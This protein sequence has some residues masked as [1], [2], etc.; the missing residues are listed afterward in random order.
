MSVSYKQLFDKAYKLHNE[1][2]IKEAEK[3]YNILLEMSPEDFNVLNLY[4]LLCISKKD[5]KKAVNLLSK[6]V[7]LSKSPYVICNLAK[8]HLACNECEKALKL[9]K[10]AA[11]MNYQDG[12]LYYSMAITYKKLKKLD[13]AAQ[14]YEKAIEINP[15]NYNAGYNLIVVYRDLKMYKEAINY[16]NRC[17]LIK[18]ESEEIYSLLSYLY[19]CV[20]DLKSAI[21]ALEKAVKINPTQYLYY[22]NLGV[23]Y[24]K[25]FDPENSILNYK[26]VIELKPNSVAALVNLSCLYRKED[27][28]LSLQYILKAREYSPKAKNV[29][30]NLSQIYKDLYKNN[31][32]IEVLNE[33]LESNSNSHEAFSLLGMN[34]MDIGDYNKALDFYEK[35][36][37]LQPDNSSYLHGKAVAL[38][39]LGRIDEFKAL[40]NTVLKKDPNTCEVRITMGMAYLA[41]KNFNKG[42]ELYRARNLSTN[43][44]RI[45]GKKIWQ[46][47]ESIEKKDIVVYSNCGLGDTLMYARYLNILAD[48]ANSVILQTDEPLLSLLQP[49]FKNIKIINKSAKIGSNFDIAIPIM[50]IPYVLKMDFSNIPAS[51]GYIKHD[52]K[53]AEKF[54]QLSIFNNKKKKIGLFLQGNKRIF[55]NRFVPIDYVLPFFEHN[56]IEFYSLHINKDCPENE[57]LVSLKQYINNYNDTAAIL[58][59]M[60]LIISIDSSVVHL[61]GSMRIKTF[62]MLPYTPEWRW[63]NDDKTTP[64]YDSISIFKQTEIGDWASVADR[65]NKSLAEL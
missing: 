13:M 17:L 40:M 47:F 29:L 49:N 38:K 41:E 12:D 43:F 26:K 35:A 11:D 3:L 33:L 46:P 39:Y 7:V 28:N 36:V 23:L 6:A 55:K 24:S 27:I 5:S 64:W 32:S 58:A 8:A 42:M 37:A 16:A 31:E 2:N 54:S 9:F 61:A 20:K 19:E 50:D 22:Y 1:G 57:N 18:P 52:T 15:A 10:Q 63:F 34:Y 14:C 48:K 45:F 21:K 53:L 59:N 60:D 25:I 62:L 44:N 30:L 51:A 56:E 65:I 4:G